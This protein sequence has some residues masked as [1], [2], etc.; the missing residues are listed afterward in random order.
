MNEKVKEISY[1]RFVIPVGPVHPALKEPVHF[2]VSLQREEVVDVDL[3]IGYAHRG[4]EA[5]AQTRNLAQALYLVERI[6][7]ICSHSHATCFVQAIEEIGGIQP[8]ERALYL[9][10]LVA[11]LER[12]HSHML[13]LGVLA[14]EI[15]FD[16]L[17][18]FALRAREKVM[19][20]FEEITGNRVQ[21]SMN[22]IGGVR[23]DLMPKSEEKI[24][25]F[26]KKIGKATCYM[27]A[28][29]QDKTVEKRLGGIGV[30]SEAEARRLCVVGPTARGSGLE[31]DTRKKDPY[32]A[33]QDLKDS[34]SLVVKTNGDAYTR[35]EVR[36]LEILESIN[37]IKSILDRLP[38]GPTAPEE[39]LF[40]LIR[41]IP[42]GEAVS[43]VEAP[44][45]ELLYF[46][47]TDGK[48][49]LDRLKVRTPTLANII[50]LKS[51]LIGRE[52]ADI[53][54]IVASI[55]PCISC[56]DR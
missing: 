28:V 22:T 44:R 48:E 26:S 30:L 13:W 39:S 29:F 56:T 55:D 7:G 1:S 46:V 14:H 35:T 27:L 10:T 42:E 50:S 6:C 41:K 38:N 19:D 23:N 21:H 12:I 24:I 52:V 33:Y 18:M 40:R 5:L 49:S 36:L 16:T 43:R 25:N 32:A 17:F 37:I 45:G 9:R 53:P 51:L 4:I 31:M 34:V 8:S 15:G 2:K 54:V 11:E 47:K 20:S 3:R